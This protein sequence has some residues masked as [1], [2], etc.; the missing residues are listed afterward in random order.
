MRPRQPGRDDE[1]GQDDEADSPQ[2]IRGRARR[3]VRARPCGLRRRSAAARRLGDAR[4]AGA[5]PRGRRRRRRRPHAGRRGLRQDPALAASGA[6]G[7]V[8]ALNCQ[9]SSTG[10]SVTSLALYGRR[11]AW[12]GYAGGNYREFTV[13]TTLRGRATFVSLFPVLVDESAAVHWRVAPGGA[14]LA[15]EQDGSVWRI[16]PVGGRTCPHPYFAKACVKVP[17]QGDASRRRRRT[18]PPPRRRQDLTRQ[19]G[20]QR[21]ADVSRCARGRDRRRG[22]RR[23]R[24]G[25]ADERDAALHRADEL[26]PRRHAARPRRGDNRRDDDRHAPSRRPQTLARPGPSPRSPTSGSTPLPAS[27]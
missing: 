3:N 23:A 19:A 1:R 15:F 14:P 17:A 6:A 24:E 13:A 10:S 9:E 5:A 2:D 26:A 25:Q 8:A 18:A 11:P 22:R 21:R 27:A 7:E 12:A 4:R 20:R 16:V